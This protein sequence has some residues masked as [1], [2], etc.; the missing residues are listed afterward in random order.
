MPFSIEKPFFSKKAQGLQLNTII[1]AILGV[2]VL[3]V[4]VGILYNQV[5]KTGKEIKNV[6]GARCPDDQ[7][8]S[9]GDCDDVIYGSF[10]NVPLGLKVCCKTPTP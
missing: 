3:L 7:V 1:I 8:K 10:V 5:T 4:I 9:I 2:I 6:T